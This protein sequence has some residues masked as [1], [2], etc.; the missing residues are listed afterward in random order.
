MVLLQRSGVRPIIAELPFK[1]FSI[2]AYAE[3]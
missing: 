1:P 2:T 3:N